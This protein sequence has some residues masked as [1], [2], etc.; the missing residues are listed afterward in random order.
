[1]LSKPL[2]R[3]APF[4]DTS[5]CRT[6][7]LLSAGPLGNFFANLLMRSDP[8]IPDEVRECTVGMLLV[9]QWYADCQTVFLDFF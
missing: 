1:M 3:V 9:Y 4:P 2:K 8:L 5:H 7:S 6:G